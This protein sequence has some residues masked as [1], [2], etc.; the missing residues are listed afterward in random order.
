MDLALL[1]NCVWWPPL[2]NLWTRR[3]L[4]PNPVGGLRVDIVNVW[5][6]VGSG[7]VCVMSPVV[8]VFVGHAIVI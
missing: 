1:P 3:R 6:F 2:L 4:V 5:L 8:S 7:R